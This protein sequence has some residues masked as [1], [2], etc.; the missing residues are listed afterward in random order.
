MKT[1][2]KKKLAKPTKKK[3]TAGK[4]TL[5]FKVLPTRAKEIRKQAELYTRGNVTALVDNTL[6]HIPVSVLKE[7]AKKEYRPTTRS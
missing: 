6:K 7:I 3:S 4:T 2:K 5:N 1:L